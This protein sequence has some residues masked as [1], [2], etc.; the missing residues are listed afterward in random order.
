M[1]GNRYSLQSQLLTSLFHYHHRLL[2]THSAKGLLRFEVS[3]T[4]RM[5]IYAEIGLPN[6]SSL[7][8]QANEKVQWKSEK[9]LLAL[10]QSEKSLEFVTRVTEPSRTEELITH[11]QKDLT[12]CLTNCWGA[13]C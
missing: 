4:N 9:A 13:C 7:V 3:I 5:F 10:D 6:F 11:E 1:D 8:S 2:H 12:P